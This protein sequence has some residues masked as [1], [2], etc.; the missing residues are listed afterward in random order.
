MLAGAAAQARP[1][2]VWRRLLE[3]RKEGPQTKRPT[4]RPVVPPPPAAFLQGI[5]ISI[6]KSPMPVILFMLTLLALLALSARHLINIIPWAL[7]KASQAM[8]A[9]VRQG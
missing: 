4:T 3:G 8:H 6:Y 2:P 9:A 1:C 7:Q 5:E